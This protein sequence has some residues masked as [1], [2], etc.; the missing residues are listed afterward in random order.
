MTDSV[1]QHLPYVRRL[2]R[3]VSRQTR[4]ATAV[5]FD[6]LVQVGAL[7][8][9]EAAGRF[10]PAY[11]VSFKT[12]AK[13]RVL[14]AMYDEL[15]RLEPHHDERAVSFDAAPVAAD[16]HPLAEAVPDPR[17][18]QPAVDTWESPLADVER[19]TKRHRF[20]LGRTAAGYRQAEIA[21]MLGISTSR[22]RQLL[23]EACTPDRQDERKPLSDREF[24]VLDASAHGLTAKE[25]G[26]QLIISPA[27]VQDHRRSVTAK[28]AAKN[29]THAVAVAYEK[30]LLP[31]SRR[32][33]LA[34]LES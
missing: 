6:D 26:D 28:L 17:A 4:G 13:K 29:I 32:R 21:T 5:D 31:L 23:K 22:V 11:G 33:R 2:A 20:V 27:T 30:G 18:P 3:R 10:D 1:E 9:L 8:L 14:G 19:L 12:F 25:I 15:R 34:G 16:G 7:G 24:E